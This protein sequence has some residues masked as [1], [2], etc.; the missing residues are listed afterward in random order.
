MR[1]NIRR[2]VAKAYDNKKSPVQMLSSLWDCIISLFT[3]FAEL[4][5]SRTISF[6]SGGPRVAL[7]ESHQKIL[8]EGAF[9]VVYK[10]SSVGRTPRTYYALKKMLM[11][12][13]ECERTV[14][15]EIEALCRFKHPCIVPLLA[16]STNQ[17]EAST[18]VKVAFL[19]F[20]YMKNGSLRTL[21]NRRL[22]A[23]SDFGRSSKS[24]STRDSDSIQ[25]SRLPGASLR[26]ILGDFADICGAFNCLHTFS[27]SYVHQDIKPDNILITDEGTPL[28]TDFGSVR[29]ADI[30][31]TSRTQSLA[32]AEEAAQFCTI[33]YRAPELFDPPRNCKLDSRTDVWGMGCLL[34]AWWF[35]Y[36]P[37]ECEFNDNGSVRLV[38]SSHSRVLSKTPV[39]PTLTSNDRIVLDIVEWM[40]NRDFSIRPFTTDIIE[41]LQETISKL[42]SCEEEF[43]AFQNC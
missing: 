41:R 4:F 17:N 16:S 35:G 13:K 43:D 32:V 28:L 42:P 15:V 22:D 21:L 36:S 23:A 14:A 37:F 5:F 8:G 18:G 1:T 6:E 39:P 12:T 31:I 10:A 30:V 9:S 33:S 26:K 3:Y 34:Y 27:P 11:Q 20:P 24:K 40:L 25:N 7:D 19:L 2:A 29:L 38:E